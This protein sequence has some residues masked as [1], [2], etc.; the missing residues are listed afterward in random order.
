MQCVKEHR[1]NNLA[2]SPSWSP[3]S[4]SPRNDSWSEGSPFCAEEGANASWPSHAF[5]SDSRIGILRTFCNS[6]RSFSIPCVVSPVFAL[7]HSV[8]RVLRWAQIGKKICCLFWLSLCDWRGR[9]IYCSWSHTD[10]LVR[11][12]WGPSTIFFNQMDLL[13][14]YSAY[15]VIGEAVLHR[16]IVKWKM[17]KQFICKSTATKKMMCGRNQPLCG[18]IR[19]RLLAHY[20]KLTSYRAA[21]NSKIQVNVMNCREINSSDERWKYNR[22]ALP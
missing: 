5:S 17:A 22:S 11:I 13:I 19:L 3:L 15:G 6:Q 20:E 9:S 14:T 8:C 10:F 2:P 18:A 21:R 12:W 1:G 16:P 4:V 7:R